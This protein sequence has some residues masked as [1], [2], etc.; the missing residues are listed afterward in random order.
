MRYGT[1]STFDC[2]TGEKGGVPLSAL[3]WLKKE[4]EKIGASVRVLWN[5]HDFG[6]YPSFEIDCRRWEE[7]EGEED[8]NEEKVKLVLQ[9]NDLEE[10]YIETFK[11]GL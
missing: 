2:P 10:R 3:A 1:W 11:K 7:L 6:S 9:L 4:T 5:P 8:D